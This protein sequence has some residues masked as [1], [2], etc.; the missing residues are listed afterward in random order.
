LKRSLI[1]IVALLSIFAGYVHAGDQNPGARFGHEM[2]YDE[3]REVTLLF[4]GFGPDGIPKGDTWIWDGADWHEVAQKGPSPRKWAAAAYDSTRRVVVLHGGRE[5]VGRNGLSLGDTWIW[6]GNQWSEILVDG[7]SVRDHHRVVYDRARDRMVLFGGW[8]GHALVNDTWEWNGSQWKLVAIGSPSPRASFGFAYHEVMGAV[9]L[10]GGQDLDQ[11]Y[12]DM[13]IWNGSSW[14]ELENLMSERRSFHG[15][16]YSTNLK[17]II[18][19]GGRNGDQLRN[20]LWIWAGRE[21]E[22]KSSDG[23]LLRGIFAS[24]F[25]R[26]NGEFLI[27][28]GGDF[29]NQ[30][31]RLDSRTWAWSADLGWRVISGGP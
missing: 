23:P 26:I 1:Y 8:N 21:W 6:D 10:A 5:G 17:S 25:D 22:Q 28:G 16:T 31:W 14:S 30:K 9:V 13:W 3:A 29:I 7:P 2:V 20:D 19:F 18:L 27:H 4:G 15:M 12:S 24:A 11:A